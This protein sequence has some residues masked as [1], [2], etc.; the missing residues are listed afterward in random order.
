MGLDESLMKL[1]LDY[2]MGKNHA[3]S[4]NHK[5]YCSFICLS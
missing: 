5:W 3:T 1:E 2:E 4:T